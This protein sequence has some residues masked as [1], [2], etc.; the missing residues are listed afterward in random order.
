MLSNELIQATEIS[1]SDLSLSRNDKSPYGLFVS[2]SF[3]AK[4]V[5]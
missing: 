4:N 2:T 5:Y 1:I 3:M